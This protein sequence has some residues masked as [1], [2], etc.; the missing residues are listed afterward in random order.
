MQARRGASALPLSTVKI[1]IASAFAVSWLAC[2]TSAADPP[3]SCEQIGVS[4][5]R[6]HV[7]QRAPSK[8]DVDRHARQIARATK[9]SLV[10]GCKTWSDDA[11]DAI[12]SCLD[13]ASGIAAGRRCLTTR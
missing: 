1:L 6:L 10:P 8:L 12:A 13:G 4:M 2:S 5:A 9:G 7:K 11:R 3:A